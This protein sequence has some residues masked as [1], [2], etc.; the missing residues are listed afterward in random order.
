MKRRDFLLAGS[1]AVAGPLLFPGWSLA[2]S[3][4]ALPAAGADGC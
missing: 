2:Q 3:V 4:V 1:A